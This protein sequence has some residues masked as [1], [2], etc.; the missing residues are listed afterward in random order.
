MCFNGRFDWI[1]FLGDRNG[2]AV[3]IPADNVMAG[4][5][6]GAGEGPDAAAHLRIVGNSRTFH[7]VDSRHGPSRPV[8]CSLPTRRFRSQFQRYQSITTHRHC[9]QSINNFINPINNSIDRNEYY[10]YI[11]IDIPCF[12]CRARIYMHL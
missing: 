4:D 5:N 1:V 6:P 8:Q 3:R 2:I 12:M 9:S 7:L 11:Y 10:I